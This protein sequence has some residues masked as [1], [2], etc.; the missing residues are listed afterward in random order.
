MKKLLFSLLLIIIANSNT[1]YGADKARGFFV[2]FGVGPR[3]PI[4]TF[5]NSTDLGYGF[6]LEFS[7]TDNQF[8]PIFL[9]AKIGYEQYPGSQ[10]YYESTDYSNFS[11]T[12]V[13]VN[14]G[15][16]ILFFSTA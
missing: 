9:F 5:S 12:S 4:S 6:N 1:I 11:T 13:P 3:V 14:T 15:I 8:I 2:S 10:G 7:Y 16:Q